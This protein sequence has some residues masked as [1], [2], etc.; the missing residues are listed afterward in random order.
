MAVINASA[1]NNAG[2]ETM[3]VS[4]I[5]SSSSKMDMVYESKFPVAGGMVTSFSV[6]L[7]VVPADMA[8]FAVHSIVATTPANDKLLVPSAKPETAWMP[9]P[10]K[11]SSVTKTPGK[12]RRTFP[13]TGN[14]FDATKFTVIDAAVPWMLFEKEIA[15][16]VNVPTLE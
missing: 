16:D 14:S 8:E 5:N 1:R 3:I 4:E 13:F 7:M 9:V 10:T 15:A 6:I 11:V 2:W 12:V